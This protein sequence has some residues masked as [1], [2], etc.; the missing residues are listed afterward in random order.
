VEG[1]TGSFL[2]LRVFVRI[3]GRL[4]AKRATASRPIQGDSLS[5]TVLGGRRGRAVSD[6]RDQQ[7]SKRGGGRVSVRNAPADAPRG[8]TRTKDLRLAVVCYGG[9]SLAIYMHGVTKEIH[10]LVT[11]SKGLE[12]SPEVDPFKGMGTESVYWRALK[13]L[14]ELQNGVRTNVIVDIISGTSAGG[15]NGVFLAKD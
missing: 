7:T 3:Q 1:A 12:R 2:H 13:G 4:S 15:I 6:R 9:V 5:A 11:A 14:Q 8:E 10:K